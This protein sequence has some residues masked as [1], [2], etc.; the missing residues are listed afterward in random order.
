[1]LIGVTYA[2]AAPVSVG[3]SGWSWGD[4]AP[5]GNTLNNV[6]FLGT[7]GFAVGEFGTVLRSDDGGG[8]WTGLPSGTKSSLSLV[9]EVDSDTVIVGGGCT[10]RESINGGESFQRVAINASEVTCPTKVASFSFLNPTTGF[11]EQAD[12]SILLTTNGGQTLQPKTPVPLNGAA[13]SKI[14]FTSPTTGFA[15]T[16]GAGGRIFRTTDG[17]NSWTQVASS[18]EAFSDLTFV[19]PTTAFAVGAGSTLL[20]STD[21][22]ASW[23]ARALA[24]PAP[25]ARLALR[26]ISCSDVTDCLIATAPAASA[27]TNQLVRT[28]DGGLTGSLVSPS[29]QNLLAVSFST[30]SNVVAVGQN[31]ATVL[32]SDGGSTFPTLISHSLGSLYSRSIRIGE[33][34]LD[35]YA[36]GDT[37]AIAATTNG[38]EDWSLLR[39]PSSGALSDVDFPTTEIGYVVNNAGT[40][41]RTADAG[42][43]WSILNS[44]GGA[45]TALLAPS[46]TTVLLTGPRG[47]RRSTNAGGRFASVNATV[48]MSRA[49]GKKRRM[50][51][52]SFDLSGGAQIAGTAMFAYGQDVL[53]STDGGAHWALIPRPLPKHPV[54]AISFVSSTSGYETSDGRTFFTDNRGRTWREILSVGAGS[55]DA[56]GQMSFT[57]VLKGYLHVPFGAGGAAN[58]LLR[59]ENGGRSW[60]PENLPAALN[61]VAAAGPVDYAGGENGTADALFQTT[62]GGFSASPSTLTLGIAGAHRLSA[63]KLKK[64]GGRVRLVGLLSPA[65]G[66][67]TVTVSHRTIGGSWH[68]RDVTVSS[69]GTFAVTVS[70][71]SQTTDFVAQWIGEGAE[72]GAGTPAARFTVSRA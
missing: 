42:L 41:L 43:S 31:G 7:R 22:G 48:V 69:S 65:L 26:H 2:L 56:P 37:S 40:V 14:Y 18:P 3:R 35:A 9:Q 30:A 61:V 1:M 36:L 45:A 15:V 59:T 25:T 72:S 49:H 46:A 6:T 68:S 32:S 64:S 38:G 57:T 12:G 58:V 17:A 70:G 29:G 47:V 51:L 5:Q 52:S 20:R 66:G 10:V 55:L 53:E 60:T 21:A 44:A 19:T 23:T 33:S 13:A 24:L 11:V 27:S 50:R 71:V 67:E 63:G 34:A 8:S 28:T 16:G 39:V 62:D 54:S 4:P